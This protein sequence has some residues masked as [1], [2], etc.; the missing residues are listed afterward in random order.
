MNLWCGIIHVAGWTVM[1][2]ILVGICGPG[3]RGRA[4]SVEGSGA[5]LICIRASLHLD[6][7]PSLD[8]HGML[9][10]RLPSKG[11]A[12]WMSG[13]RTCR[14]FLEKAI[15]RL[16]RGRD[17]PRRGHPL[18]YTTA[19]RVRLQ[20][21]VCRRGTAPGTGQCGRVVGG[22][23]EGGCRLAQLVEE[24]LQGERP[25]APADRAERLG[26]ASGAM[27]DEG[28]CLVPRDGGAKP[29][30]RGRHLG[31]HRA[32]GLRLQQVEP[33]SSLGD[34]ESHLQTLLVAEEVDLTPAPRVDLGR[35]VPA[36]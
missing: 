18:P 10:V 28:T 4:S 25:D 35:G 22:P 24:R 5:W 2:S 33:P 20:R 36:P 1:S 16:G 29:L 14:D 17:A 31:S 15:A 3:P 21:A 9:C 8:P 27:H 11:G 13:G 12:S 23:C 19:G 6:H 26:G 32:G 34:E 30:E 7:Q